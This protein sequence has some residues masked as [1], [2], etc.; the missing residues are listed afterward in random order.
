MLVLE[1]R[2]SRFESEVG[3]QTR[4]ATDKVSMEVVTLLLPRR[5][6]FDSVAIHQTGIPVDA[7]R[8]R[9]CNVLTLD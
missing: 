7:T 4:I 5:A 1:T 3:Y 8:A 6:R 9:E 2:F